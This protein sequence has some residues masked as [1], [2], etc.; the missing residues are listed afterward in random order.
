MTDTEDLETLWKAVN[1]ELHQGEL[2]PSLWEAAREARPICIEDDVLVLGLT[3]HQIGLGSHLTTG[4]NRHRMREVLERVTGEPLDLRVIEGTTHEQ[5]VG[6]R[7]REAA[8]AARA[9][10]QVAATRAA[11]ALGASWETLR[12]QLTTKYAQAK[13]RQFPQHLARY[14][15]DALAMTL[16]VE[17]RVRAAEGS[18]DAVHDRQLARV[19]DK[20][21]NQCGVASPVVALEYMRLRDGRR[22]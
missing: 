6:R 15:L 20:I 3:P 11:R 8:A 5:W 10:A 22:S 19:L 16:D 4:Q 13:A 12:E 14:M 21:A 2:L 17:T 1:D 9:E 7:E 18:D